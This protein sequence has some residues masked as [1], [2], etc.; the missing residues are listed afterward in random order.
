MV[1]I[2][3]KNKF[4]FSDMF[5][6]RLHNN[7]YV[8][9]DKYHWALVSVNLKNMKMILY[10][11]KYYFSEEG[12]IAMQN[13]AKF[14]DYYNEKK[15]R[16]NSTATSKN[17]DI[18]TTISSQYAE[19][20]FYENRYDSE[21]SSNDEDAPYNLT[22]ATTNLTYNSEDDIYSNCRRVLNFDEIESNEKEQDERK[23]GYKWRFKYAKNPMQHNNNETDSGV[24][25]CKFMEYLT[26]EEPILFTKDDTEYFRILMT[27]E[28]LQSKLM[29][30]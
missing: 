28:F 3:I 29:T 13:L 17:F 19:N 15:N 4:P 6:Q 14:F 20:E 25:V 9:N 8:E 21:E 2:L 5:D 27:I 26:R 23:V 12:K 24:F 1:P 18:K 22:P 16:K 30:G 10:D 7:R 11:S